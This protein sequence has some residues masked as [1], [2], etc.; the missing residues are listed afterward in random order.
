[1]PTGAPWVHQASMCRIS[2]STADKLT[3]RPPWK[4]NEVPD[5]QGAESLQHPCPLL[6]LGHT[7]GR[8][9][10]NKA[11][12]TTCRV[13]RDLGRGPRG[14]PRGLYW[15]KMVRV[16]PGVAAGNGVTLPLLPS[17]HNL[18]AVPK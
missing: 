15:R 1:M 11:L 13:H 4:H 14:I 12:L 10:W 9:L 3:W 8:M 5:V 7:A 16:F 2:L 6:L 18:E 17:K